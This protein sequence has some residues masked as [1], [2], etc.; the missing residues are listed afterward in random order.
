[1]SGH[2]RAPHAQMCL[3]RPFAYARR[4]GTPSRRLRAARTGRPARAAR[5]GRGHGSAAGYGA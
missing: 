3:T 5:F 2:P 1:M 4:I